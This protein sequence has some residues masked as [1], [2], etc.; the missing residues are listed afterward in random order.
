MNF[1][2]ERLRHFGFSCF[3]PQISSNVLDVITCWL[4][5][6]F[7]LLTI[8][9]QSETKAEIWRNLILCC[10]YIFVFPAFVFSSTSNSV[11][12]TQ[13]SDLLFTNIVKL[14]SKAKRKSFKTQKLP[15]RIC[16]HIVS[17][18]VSVHTFCK[19]VNYSTIH[20]A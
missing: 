16:Q 14:T 3:I 12:M 6:S 17:S 10:F 2:V 1:Y 8:F 5:L 15:Y 13:S 20:T 4:K 7:S 9:F 19:S 11:L 18:L